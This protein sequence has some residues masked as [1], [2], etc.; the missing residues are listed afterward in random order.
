MAGATAIPGVIFFGSLDG[1]PRAYGSQ[2]GKIVWDYDTVRSFSTMNGVPAH[3]GSLNG[4][5]AVVVGGR[6]Y[7]N[8]GHSRFREATVMCF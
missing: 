5:G 4:P 1:Q 8:S 3:A 2:A 6:V 7:T